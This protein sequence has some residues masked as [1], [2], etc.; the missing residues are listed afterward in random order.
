[1]PKRAKKTSEPSRP[2]LKTS[3]FRSNERTFAGYVVDPEDLSRLFTVDLLVDGCIVR[4]TV[5]NEHVRALADDGIGDGCYGFSLSLA[6][7]AV[8][9]GH[10]VEARLSNLGERIGE[11]IALESSA[12][13]AE[14]IEGPGYLR[15]LGGLR[16]SGWIGKNHEAA[17]HINITVDGEPV[18]RVRALGWSHIGHDE[19]SGR[20][21]RAFDFHLPERFADGCIHRVSVSD[22]AGEALVGVALPFVAFADGLAQSISSLG[23]LES[24]RLR[25]ELFDQL[26]PM[27]IPLANYENWR[28]R[29]P[30]PSVVPTAMKMAV[31][32]VG[33]GK[34]ART[35]DS[36][37][38]QS[39]VNW[40]AAS[41]VIEGQQTC[42]D[43]G[44]ARGFL[45]DDGKDCDFVVFAV[46]GCAFETDALARI[47]TAFDEFED[48]ELVYCDLDLQS[49]DGRRWPLAFP[50]FDYERMLEQGYC[51]HVFG[52]RRGSAL[53]ALAG[54]AASLYRLFNFLLDDDRSGLTKVVHIP[55]AQAVIPGIEIAAASEALAAASSD[56]LSERGIPGE[57]TIG[58]GTLLPA[59]R[60]KRSLGA[61]STTVI[62]PTRN[63]VALLRRCLETIRP[64]IEK[65]S[66]DI[67][68]IDNGST[69]PET[70]DYL[71]EI[72]ADNIRVLKIDGPFNF[73]RLNNQAVAAV[74]SEYL[75]L[76]NNDIEA[77]DDEWLEE[78]L[79]RIV[80]P[81]VGAVGAL[82][83]WPSGVVQHGGVVLGPSF[84]AHHAFNDRVQGDPGYGDMLRAAHECSAVTAACMLTR[85]SDYNDVGGMD[86][87]SLAVA[88]NDVDYC[89]KLRASGK[90]IVFTPHAK[91]LHL[92]S[93]S[94]GRDNRPDRKARFDRELQT[95]RARWSDVIADDPYYN[96]VLSLDPIPYSALAWPVRVRAPRKSGPALRKDVPPGF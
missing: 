37:D 83:H 44:E 60:I 95:L 39:E 70:I 28:E 65:A 47:A 82:L 12:A 52:M 71:A 63:R 66:A 58:E 72:N 6:R 15:W 11:P 38:Q 68:I 85:R 10:A 73:A 45:E 26:L 23:N 78:M 13:D 20:A 94:R 80:E 76:L 4:S 86:E 90:R 14:G 40:V 34:A 17:P 88:F 61:G 62:I 22:E 74:S 36:L 56:H 93:A 54:G 7:N 29:F 77:V 67:L 18:A 35:L 46:S 5:A 75:C 2:E 91:L 42:F 89:L 3:F 48:A 16:F 92:E 84:A 25:G 30:L 79:S 1:M 59:V 87:I 24:E 64:A 69:D 96:P 32:L 31:V 81:Q 41:L 50:A 53:K 51:A 27:S 57:M 55:G 8:E 21:V 33:A 43:P 19:D 49:P 9:D